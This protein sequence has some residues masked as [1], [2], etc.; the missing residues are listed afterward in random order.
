M[1]TRQKAADFFEGLKSRLPFMQHMRNR[2]SAV[3]SH[4]TVKIVMLSKTESSS[5]V[6]PLACWVCTVVLTH[7]HTHT[8]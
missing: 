5:C 8:H 2:E 7:S 4:T 1:S 6:L 3:M